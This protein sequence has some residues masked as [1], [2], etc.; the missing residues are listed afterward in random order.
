[1]RRILLSTGVAL[2]VFL[3]F[4]WRAAIK[5]NRSIPD[6]PFQIAGNLYYV[7]S[8]G[9]TSF[10]L[11]GPEGH[12]L[13]DG[14]YP[15]TAPLIEGSIAKLGF[16]IRDVKVLLNTHAHS[17]HAGGLSELKH[18][19]GAQVWISDGDAPL[20]EAGGAG[21]VSYGPLRFLGVGRF[22]AAHVDHRIRDGETVHVGPLAV[23]AHITAGHTP[24]CTSWAI[25][26]RDGDRELLAVDVCSLSLLPFMRFVEPQRYPGIREDFERSFV[27]LRALP[28][29]IFLG[30]HAS[31]FGLGRKRRL[32]ATASDPVAPFIDPEGYRAY[33][34]RSEARFRK[35]VRDQQD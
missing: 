2:L 34:D 15:E 29:D 27:T 1:L 4:L 3:F 8:T 12:I 18:D 19:C 9:V 25:P 10:L 20:V 31:F 11:T 35:A 23:T 21:D 32:R 24:G 28:A 30:S 14:G 16:N 22:P 26:V 13:I 5:R 7:G 17:D 6:E 33:L